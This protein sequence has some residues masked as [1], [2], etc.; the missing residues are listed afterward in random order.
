MA[1]TSFKQSTLGDLTKFNSFLAGNESTFRSSFVFLETVDVVVNTSSISFTNLNSSYS[2]QYKHLEIRGLG[3]TTRAGQNQDTYT[4][5]INNDS[6]ANY[7]RYQLNG[8]GSN[9]ASSGASGQTYIA[10]G[11]TGGGDSPTGAYGPFSV[12]ILNAFDTTKNKGVLSF[13]ASHTYDPAGGGPGKYTNLRSGVRLNTNVVD[14][15]EIGNTSGSD[16]IPGSRFSL[17][18]IE[19]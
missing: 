19:G 9:I 13:A 6:G 5:R 8:D 7:T 14:S 15:L 2:S 17:Y 4:L 1:I 3:T 10:L 11:Q 18:G 12:L 16:Y